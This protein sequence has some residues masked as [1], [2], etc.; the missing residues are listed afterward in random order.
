MFFQYNLTESSKL[1]KAHK[2]QLTK[3]SKTLMFCRHTNLTKHDKIII[4]RQQDA[5][6]KNK[7]EKS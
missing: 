4:V 7:E 2:K 3:Y 5:A 1:A 6:K